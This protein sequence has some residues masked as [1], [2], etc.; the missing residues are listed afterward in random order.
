M[1]A[2]EP[3]PLLDP[4][5]IDACLVGLAGWRRDGDRL[6]G[7]YRTHGWKGSAML[8]GAVAHLCEVAWHHPELVVTW[9]RV[10]I[11]LWTHE[12]GGVTARDTALAA[13]LDRFL[14]WAP[15]APL[16]GTPTGP[17]FGYLKP[18]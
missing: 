1:T 14:R 16:E 13:A 2:R 11:R 3:P 4:A 9:D 10:E 12:S 8:A 18:D 5:T 7:V 15:P 6:I 17:R